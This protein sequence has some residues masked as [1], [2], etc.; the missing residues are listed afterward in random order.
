MIPVFLPDIVNC[1]DEHDH[2]WKYCLISLIKTKPWCENIQSVYGGMNDIPENIDDIQ[3]EEK[4]LI[5]NSFNRYFRDKDLISYMMDN[6][7]QRAAQEQQRNGEMSSITPC[8]SLF[9]F[10]SEDAIDEA[11][12]CYRRNYDDD[13]NSDKEEMNWDKDHDFRVKVHNYTETELNTSRIEAINKENMNLCN[14]NR[15]L[16][17]LRDLKDD[18][19]SLQQSE[20]IEAFLKICGL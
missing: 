19:G 17:Y 7:L 11:M 9:S 15:R 8:G 10:E 1:Q 6:P 3:E 5:L 14:K 16:I 12:K 20:V 18:V 2:Y 13:D 4:K